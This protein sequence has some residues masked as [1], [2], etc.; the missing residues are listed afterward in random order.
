MRAIRVEIAEREWDKVI[1]F[2]AETED[3]EILAVQTGRNSL[4]VVSE[5]DCSMARAKAMI[6]AYF[7]EETVITPLKR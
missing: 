1:S 5:G 3:D 2:V 6:Y 7:E 4:L